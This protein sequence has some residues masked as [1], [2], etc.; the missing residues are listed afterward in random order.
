MRVKIKPLRDED[1]LLLAQTIRDIDRLEVE[2]M[3]GPDLEQALKICAE[4]SFRGKA[5]YADGRLV[6][7][8]GIGSRTPLSREGSPWLLATTAMD[9][10]AVRKAFLKHSRA[11]FEALIEGYHSCWNYVHEANRIAVK[12]L[13]WL[14]F[15]FTGEMA[16]V[17]GEPFL[18]F[19]KEA[20]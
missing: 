13:K 11:E 4:T 1:L 16:T 2:A 8:W 20:A 19:K 18:F 6:A 12:W 3:L 5:G 7:V 10:P 9:D 15:S 14:G 17:G